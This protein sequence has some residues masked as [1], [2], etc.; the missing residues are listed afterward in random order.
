VA[1]A[2]ATYDNGYSC[3]TTVP[4]GSPDRPA[5]AFMARSHGYSDDLF[6]ETRMT[7]GEHIE[8]LRT[9][10]LRALKGLLFCLIFG[11]VL[12]AVGTMLKAPYLGVGWPMVRFITAPVREQLRQFYD[13]R[14]E[15]LLA[16]NDEGLAAARMAAAPQQMRLRFSPESVAKLRGASDVPGGPVDVT[17]EVNPI[18]VYNSQERVADFIR[19]R[20]LTTLSVQESMVVYMK[21]SL[22]CS[23][24][25][26]SPWVF[27]Q[28]WSFVAAGLYP[29]EKH[30]V[31]KYLPLSLSLFLGGVFLC[32]FAVIPKSIEALLWFND[33]IGL[34]P[35]LRLNEWLGFAILLPLV[36]G[37]SFQ[38]P[39]IMLFLERIGV[40]DVAT[41]LS[42]WRAAVFILAIV[43]AVITPTQDV[44]TLL[45]MWLPLCALYFL[46]IYLCRLSR[47]DDPDDADGRSP[48]DE[49]VEA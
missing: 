11:F 30:Y 4:G 29:H 47:T 46:G 2:P 12:D 8:E 9:H 31:H 33:W 28:A 41:Y 44:F 21:V 22:L 48:Q 16:E 7:F 19:P 23:L 36:F 27:W 18:D 38:T 20:E 49:L 39:L 10:L 17:V 35:D 45:L 43:A 40:M 6:A 37:L 5:S 25:L 32:Q 15:R 24:I 26:A 14:M 13:R 34:T 1:P 42:S 3:C